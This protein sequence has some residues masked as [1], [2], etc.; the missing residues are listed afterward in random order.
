[1][2]LVGGPFQPHVEAVDLF[3]E[4]DHVP[5]L[6]DSDAD[7]VEVGALPPPAGDAGPFGVLVFEAEAQV[8]LIFEDGQPGVAHPRQDAALVVDPDRLGGHF[9][10]DPV[11]AGP[12]ARADIE[13]RSRAFFVEKVHPRGDVVKPAVTGD[14]RVEDQGRGIGH[15]RGG[16]Q[17]IVFVSLDDGGSMEFPRIRFVLERIFHLGISFGVVL[18]RPL[19]CGK[20]RV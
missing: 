3:R 4:E 18:P 7:G 5:L 6:G 20:E 11:F 2:P 14:S 19:E 13:R 17:G 16:K 1:M 15:V 12:E 9:E 8:K 10:M